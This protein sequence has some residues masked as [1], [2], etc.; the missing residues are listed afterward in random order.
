MTVPYFTRDAIVQKSRETALFA[1]PSKTLFTAPPRPR[2]LVLLAP[3]SIIG[4][5][6]LQCLGMDRLGLKGSEIGSSKTVLVA[7]K[8]TTLVDAN[9]VLSSFFLL[10]FRHL[11][12]KG[13]KQSKQTW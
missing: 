10:S 13:P 6:S 3:P 1:P 7:A 5:L 9:F 12:Q 8:T 11:V 2:P 4:L